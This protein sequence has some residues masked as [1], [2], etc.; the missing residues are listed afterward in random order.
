M[1]THKPMLMK[2]ADDI[3]DRSRSGRGLFAVSGFPGIADGGL[4][5]AGGAGDESGRKDLIISWA[6]GSR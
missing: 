6:Y 2:E 3:I 4:D 1:I 5:F